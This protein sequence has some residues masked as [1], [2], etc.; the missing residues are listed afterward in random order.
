[1]T[2][3]TK[4]CIAFLFSRLMELLNLLQ[5]PGKLVGKE[6]IFTVYMLGCVSLLFCYG[7]IRSFKRANESSI[8]ATVRIICLD[9][10]N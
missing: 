4:T 8:Q 7:Q 2:K 5:I 9:T 6:W 10:K 1:M 3:P